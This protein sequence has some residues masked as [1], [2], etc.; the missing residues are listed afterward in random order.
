M[1]TD[2]LAAGATSTDLVL[3]D[4]LAFA[5]WQNVG[6]TLQTIHRLTPIWLGVWLNYGERHYGETY[7]QALLFTDHSIDSLMQYK[8]V[9][10]AVPPEHRIDGLTYTHYRHA[11]KL[12]GQMQADALAYAKSNNLTTAEFKQY[13]DTLIGPP[14]R[15]EQQQVNKT[16]QL[17]AADALSK[18]PLLPPTTHKAP[19]PPPAMSKGER[20]A[21]LW[22][23]WAILYGAGAPA[24]DA[25]TDVGD[26]TFG[27]ILDGI[28]AGTNI[29]TW[30]IFPDW[31]IN[32][33]L[34]L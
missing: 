21:R 24:K 33:E 20:A 30:D 8:W 23:A 6:A 26:D 9:M 28:L 27:L 10:G 7:T 19:P 17:V 3:P 18:Q 25:Q 11:A 12:R 16:E 15:Q 32:K 29:E 34:H 1:S 5:E 22:A 2:L 13:V 14:P 4:N 31:E